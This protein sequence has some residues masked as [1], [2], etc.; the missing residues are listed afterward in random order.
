MIGTTKLRTRYPVFL[1]ILMTTA[2]VIALSSTCL[3]DNQHPLRRGILG[4]HDHSA[5]NHVHRDVAGTECAR[6]RTV[7][8]F[9]FIQNPANRVRIDGDSRTLATVSCR[10]RS[11]DPLRVDR[12]RSPPF[13]LS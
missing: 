2:V 11:L 13:Q 6:Q 9:A 12:G 8:P 5:I 4:P 1:G 7:T 3:I 10:R